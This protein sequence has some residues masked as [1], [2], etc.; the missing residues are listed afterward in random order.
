MFF[1]TFNH[2]KY[3]V[4]FENSNH[5]IEINMLINVLMFLENFLRYLEVFKIF[6]VIRG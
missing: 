3:N 2:G 6:C 5:K 4:D 1:L